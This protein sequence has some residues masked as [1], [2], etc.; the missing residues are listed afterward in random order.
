[1]L[2]RKINIKV[3]IWRRGKIS[4]GVLNFNLNRKSGIQLDK[5]IN[6]NERNPDELIALIN[7]LRILI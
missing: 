3:E 1:M 6:E 7:K 2:L 4:T 5:K